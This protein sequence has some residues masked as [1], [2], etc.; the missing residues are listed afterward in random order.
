MY[1]ATVAINVSK[2][3][4]LAL[5]LILQIQTLE[6][7]S[8]DIYRIQHQQTWMGES[9]TKLERPIQRS[10]TWN[11]WFNTRPSRLACYTSLKTPM[12]GLL[13]YKPENFKLPREKWEIRQTHFVFLDEY[14]RG[15]VINNYSRLDWRVLA[16]KKCLITS[17]VP[18]G[19][20]GW[21]KF[22]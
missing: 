5:T 7:E 4:R 1:K 14:T 16:F 8:E 11:N 2:T 9:T 13:D 15:V 12:R 6:R 21:K 22:Y 3:S 17:L 10:T 20:Y 19:F 18:P